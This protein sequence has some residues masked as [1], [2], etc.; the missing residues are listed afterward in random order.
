MRNIIK[1]WIEARGRASLDA[2][3]SIV[4]LEYWQT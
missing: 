3:I 4:A 2:M 1:E